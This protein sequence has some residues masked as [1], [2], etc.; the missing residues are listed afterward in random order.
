MIE[1]IPFMLF[2]IGVP[3]DA[4]QPVEFE[5]QMVLFEDQESCEKA[6]NE[7]VEQTNVDRAN[8]GLTYHAFCEAIPSED[9]FSAMLRAIEERVRRQR[10]AE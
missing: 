2:L 10:S 1:L 6:A 7:L 9:E 4:A 3:Q 5:R 8:S